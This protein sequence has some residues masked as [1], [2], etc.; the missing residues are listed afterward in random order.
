MLGSPAYIYIYIYTYI[1]SYL[2][3]ETA[4]KA[5]TENLKENERKNGPFLI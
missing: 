4:G 2:L 5:E 3:I 1:E